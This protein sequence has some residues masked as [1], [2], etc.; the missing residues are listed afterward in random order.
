MNL[1][2]PPFQIVPG[3][4]AEDAAAEIVA[5]FL[6]IESLPLKTSRVFKM[7]SDCLGLEP[8]E[9]SIAVGSSLAEA[10]DA[11]A[12]L[13]DKPYHSSQHCCEV[14]LSSYFLSLLGGLDKQETAEIVLAA[15]TH[16]FQH[17]GKPNGDIPFR[18]ERNSVNKAEP[19]LAKA[20]MDKTRRQKLAALTLATST[21]IGLPIA[22]ACHAH[23]AQGAP[24]PEIPPS[25]PELAELGNDPL[26][27]IQAL[28][29]CEADILPSIG[30]TTDYALKLQEKLSIEWGARLGL[31]DKLR[32]IDNQ[33]HTFFADN[34]FNPNIDKIRQEILKRLHNQ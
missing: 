21:A 19:Y 17:D 6:S 5:A 26:T 30:L 33:R 34:Y 32:F 24:L 22:R 3:Q 2:R 15:L 29:L 8:E 13:H 28:I 16:D 27:A 11:T 4:S 7:L 10:V 18:L 1:S 23:H 25:A 12:A 20:G 9:L 31:E 14:M